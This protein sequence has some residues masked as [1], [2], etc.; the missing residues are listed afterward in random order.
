M[1]MLGQGHWGGRCTSGESVSHASPLV[2]HCPPT[3]ARSQGTSLPTSPPVTRPG[4]WPPPPQ[5]RLG[6]R[7]SL[8]KTRRSNPS[9]VVE[10]V[11]KT[12][13]PSATATLRVSGVTPI[14]RT[15]STDTEQRERRAVVPAPLGESWRP[16]T[17]E[18]DRDP[19]TVVAVS[20][21]LEGSP[22]LQEMRK[23]RTVLSLHV[24]AS[25][26]P[27]KDARSVMT[28]LWWPCGWAEGC[29]TAL[30][31]LSG[32]VAARAAWWSESACGSAFA[33]QCKGHGLPT[34]ASLR[35]GCNARLHDG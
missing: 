28:Q 18:G 1:C 23:R 17:L 5:P 29:G 14:S 2:G 9:M 15:R 31:V 12:R 3:R 6:G 20:S 8:R 10:L 22:A 26:S 34:G 35:H 13:S 4:L 16:G 19:G 21:E 32:C 11:G 27:Q 33:Q 25:H 24:E 30:S 7:E